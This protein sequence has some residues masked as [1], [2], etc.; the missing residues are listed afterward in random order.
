MGEGRHESSLLEEVSKVKAASNTIW[1]FELLKQ[2]REPKT[3]ITTTNKQTNKAA[4]NGLYSLISNLVSLVMN[5][6][7]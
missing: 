6:R 3:T 1:I 4:A 5:E 2:K 7:H